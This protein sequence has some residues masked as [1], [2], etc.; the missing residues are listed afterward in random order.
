M[1]ESS[2]Y[3]TLTKMPLKQDLG[4]SLAS[5][6]ARVDSYLEDYTICISP[7]AIVKIILQTALPE[8]QEV[9]PGWE[10]MKYWD[11][12]DLWDFVEYADNSVGKESYGIYFV[13]SAMIAY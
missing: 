8:Y 11:W 6:T 4:E 3:R 7:R 1:F 12:S 5:F 13:F 9:M 2:F 10:D